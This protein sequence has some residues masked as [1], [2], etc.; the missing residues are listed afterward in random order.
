MAVRAHEG[1]H[2]LITAEL[3]GPLEGDATNGR[4]TTAAPSGVHSSDESAAHG[5]RSRRHA[6]P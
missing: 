2:L 4:V 3:V 1:K 6:A 5:W